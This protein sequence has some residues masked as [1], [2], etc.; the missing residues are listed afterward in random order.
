MLTMERKGT[1]AWGKPCSSEDCMC[2]GPVA[3]SP[4]QLKK[5]KAQ[6]IGVH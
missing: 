3:E 1:E 6:D 2:K 5:P 4:F